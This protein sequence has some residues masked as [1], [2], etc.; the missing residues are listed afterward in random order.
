[1]K[2]FSKKSS[3][4]YCLLES[5]IKT[6]TAR[7]FRFSQKSTFYDSATFRQDFHQGQITWNKGTSVYIKLF[8]FN[9]CFSYFFIDRPKST[10]TAHEEFLIYDVIIVDFGNLTDA[11]DAVKRL[12]GRPCAGVSVRLYFLVMWKLLFL[13]LF[14]LHTCEI[15]LRDILTQGIR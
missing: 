10:K 14:H 7:Q 9:M 11:E 15:C 8:F 1:M 12:D 5:N 13:A 6:G 2:L 4:L 3:F